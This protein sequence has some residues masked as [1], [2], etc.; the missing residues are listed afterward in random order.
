MQFAP[1]LSEVVETLD[2]KTGRFHSIDAARAVVCCLVNAAAA[3]DYRA[4][5]LVRWHYPVISLYEGI[6]TAGESRHK[7][8]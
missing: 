7:P 2:L 5:G 1:V 3:D 4:S 8:E 6:S